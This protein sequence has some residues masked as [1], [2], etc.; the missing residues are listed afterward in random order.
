MT[1]TIS[2]PALPTITANTLSRQQLSDLRI[3]LLQSS[4]HAFDYLFEGLSDVCREFASSLL[5]TQLDGAC[6]PDTGLE[7]EPTDDAIDNL[8]DDL[9][10]LVGLNVTVVG[11]EATT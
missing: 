3:A 2:A 6:D 5:N 11:S 9:F 8:S 1:T 10:A 4:D 7:L